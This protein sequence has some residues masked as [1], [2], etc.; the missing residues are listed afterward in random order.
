[1][2]SVDTS[3]YPGA[4][5]PEKFFLLAANNISTTLTAYVAPNQ[6][7][8]I[9]VNTTVGFPDE[10]VISIDKE[11]IYYRS[12]TA[13]SFRN[14]TRGYDNTIAFQHVSG[15][16]VELRWVAAHHNRVKNA[17]KAIERTLGINPQGL[18]PD[19]S[20]RLNAYFNGI[21]KR[22]SR[23]FNKTD[24]TP[25]EVGY[26]NGP[27]LARM[28]ISPER[29]V[30]V[31]KYA[32]TVYIDGLAQ[33]QNDIFLLVDNT[34]ITNI[35]VDDGFGKGIITCATGSFLGTGI[36]IGDIVVVKGTATNND[37]YI[38]DS[39]LSN[40]QI[41][42]TET[43]FGVNGSV[44]AISIVDISNVN[45]PVK[46]VFSIPVAFASTDE[47][48][49]IIILD[50]PTVLQNVRVDYEIK[51]SGAIVTFTDPIAVLAD[52]QAPSH[53]GS[54]VASGI[55]LFTLDI[56][57]TRALVFKLHVTGTLT[58][59]TSVKIEIF[60]K[61]DLTELQYTNTINLTTP[62]VDTLVWHFDNRDDIS[63][64][65]MYIKVTD[66]AAQAFNYTLTIEVEALGNNA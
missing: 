65:N 23:I 43:I 6:A 17:V 54:V 48:D 19:L 49:A 28:F 44:G 64:N 3:I 34:Q 26:I 36:S 21:N 1:M 25:T 61:S 7:T 59:S 62:L 60:G 66:L 41:K 37:A 42:V 24:G 52:Y 38:V 58:P 20:T 53:S 63:L 9:N 18:Y 14:I 50:P 35:A 22:T 27:R 57:R 11:V 45:Y 8:V 29:F 16:A 47:A 33:I 10:G 51:N 30:K 46:D 40:T 32:P 55:D 12:K 5:D 13:G 2:S 39:V 15:A 31:S 56:G 4:F